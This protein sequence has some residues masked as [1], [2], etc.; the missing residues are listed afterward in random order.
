MIEDIK[1]E[2]L[3]KRIL[4]GEVNFSAEDIYLISS[5]QDLIKIFLDFLNKMRVFLFTMRAP[6][7]KININGFN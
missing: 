7:A 3:K 1:K 4:N 5:N 2:N 6:C